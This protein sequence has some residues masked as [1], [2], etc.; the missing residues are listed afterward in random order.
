MSPMCFGLSQMQCRLNSGWKFV[1]SANSRKSNRLSGTKSVPPDHSVHTW[2]L[3]MCINIQCET[4][5]FAYRMFCSFCF[6]FMSL[7]TAEVISRQHPLVTAIKTISVK[8]IIEKP[9]Y[10]MYIASIHDHSICVSTFSVKHTILLIA[11]FV[12]FVSA[13]CH[14]QQLRSYR[15]ST[16]LLQL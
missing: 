15:D 3:Y 11:C 2:P 16:R 5:D 13:L 14:S 8:W 6:G 9:M 1:S 7:S 12:L 10:Y 4:H